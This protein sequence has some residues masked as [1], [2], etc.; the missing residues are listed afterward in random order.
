MWME[1]SVSIVGRLVVTIWLVIGSVWYFKTCKQRHAYLLLVGS[2]IELIVPILQIVY[3]ICVYPNADHSNFKLNM[4]AMVVSGLMTF[5]Y[6]C[7]SIGFCLLI[8]KIKNTPS[9]K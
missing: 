8:D 4:Y 3:R 7:F 5:G 1:L 9:V 6:L 2:I